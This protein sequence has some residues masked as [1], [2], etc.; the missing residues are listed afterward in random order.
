MSQ[1]EKPV[2]LLCGGARIIVQPDPEGFDESHY[3]DKTKLQR[4]GDDFVTEAGIV[5]P[6]TS[7]D[8]IKR[9]ALVGTV[10]AVGPVMDM[11]FGQDG[12][13]CI[14]VGSRVLFGEFAGRDL[15]KAVP[16][17]DDCVVMDEDDVIALLGE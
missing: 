14:G 7:E 2:R 13:Q 15:E 17:Y 9:R 3:G 5:V 11:R 6:K 1:N 16:G 4:K 10:I 12:E 8:N